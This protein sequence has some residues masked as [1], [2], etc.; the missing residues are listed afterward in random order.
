MNPYRARYISTSTGS[1]DGLSDEEFIPEPCC[2]SHMHSLDPKSQ[3]KVVPFAERVTNRVTLR[4]TSIPPTGYYKP[5]RIGDL[6]AIP[7]EPTSHLE[8]TRN[9]TLRWTVPGEDLDDGIPASYEIFYSLASEKLK[10][11]LIGEKK[12]DLEAGVEDNATITLPYYGS[13]LLTVRALDFSTNRGKMSN[14][15]RITITKLPVELDRSVVS[16]LDGEG[17]KTLSIKNSAPSLG[18]RFNTFDLM[19]IIICGVALV[20]LLAGLI[21]MMLYCRK[22][23]TSIIN[24]SKGKKNGDG[25]KISAISDSKSPIHWSASELLGE[26]EKRHSFFGGSGSPQSEHRNRD[27]ELGA[28]SSENS[29]PQLQPPMSLKIV[30]SEYTGSTRSRGSPDSYDDPD[31]PTPIPVSVRHVPRPGSQSGYSVCIDNSSNSSGNNEQIHCP[32]RII[33]QPPPAHYYTS[34][35]HVS[36][37]GSNPFAHHSHHLSSSRDDVM[38]NSR[39]FPHHGPEIMSHSMQYEPDV[40]GSFSSINSKKRNITMV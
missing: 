31:C 36:T 15:A 33:Q 14:I 16:T 4:V 27:P 34:S 13:F 18:K 9:V 5:G 23:E 2:G 38:Y 19:L 11:T 10:W 35:H 21:V 12:A 30:S 7:V 1:T 20:I 40:Q 37:A 6:I 3:Y 22:G 26:H 28:N 29:D 32:N 24:T 8:L 39:H 25:T 17:G